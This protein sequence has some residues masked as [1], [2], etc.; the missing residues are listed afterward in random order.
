LRKLRRE[1][2]FRIGNPLPRRPTLRVPARAYV[3]DIRGVYGDA[4]QS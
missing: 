1:Y 2:F 4:R 3:S